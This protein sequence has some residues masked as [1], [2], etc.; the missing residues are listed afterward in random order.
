MNQRSTEVTSWECPIGSEQLVCVS[1]LEL[2]RWTAIAAPHVDER[3]MARTDTALHS[4]AQR[5][6]R[7]E[8]VQ[9]HAA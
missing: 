5:I 3:F 1:P 7:V 9:D 8:R 6:R 2:L 4:L